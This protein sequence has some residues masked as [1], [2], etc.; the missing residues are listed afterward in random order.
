MFLYMSRLTHG[1]FCLLTVMIMVLMAVPVYAQGQRPSI[2]RDTEIEAIFK[3]WSEPLLKAAGMGEDSVNIILVQSPQVNAFVAGGANIFFFTGLLQKTESADEVVGVLAHELG[4]IEG[5]HLIST[6]G[7]FERASYQSILGTV[8]GIGAAIATGSGE[9]ANAIIS[10]TN[11]IATRNF[12]SHSRI[13][14]SSA[15]QAAF[16]YLNE[17]GL[18]PQ[19]LASFFEKLKGQEFAPTSQ[20]SEYVRTH[21]L[22]R[23]RIEAVETLI[24]KSPNKDV[25]SPAHWA[26]QHARMKAKLIGFLDPGRVAWIYDDTDDSIPAR[27]ARAIAAYRQNEIQWALAS[28]DELIMLEPDNPYF[29]ELKGQM[30]VDF[31][32]VEEAL[33]SYRKAVEYIPD[34][35][36]LRIAL[37]HALI[38]SQQGDAALRE[39]IDHLNRAL[40][41]E[42]RS[43][44]ARRLL[45]T[46]YGRLG[47]TG[48][49]DL[50][51]AEEAVLARNIP[52]AK[53]KAES[54]LGQFEE[55]SKNALR[56]QDLL[57]HIEN[58][59]SL[60]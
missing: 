4:H 18:N 25:Q 9:A 26:D 51:L 33:P 24:Q 39:A 46:A 20:Q 59:E 21:P 35:G 23:N 57:K 13:N 52:Y 58:L 6:R 50:N 43:G 32:R 28:M 8:L 49:A 22:T 54:A 3:E 40:R 15:D 45:A 2:I 38:E 30:L 31:S 19:G 29:H 27:Y 41:D 14:E 42:S 10:G 17:S 53:A 36:L 55:G 1:I 5:G 16:R 34:A 48:L 44:R 60:L 37:A 11:H 7:A 56:A 12:L 47:Q